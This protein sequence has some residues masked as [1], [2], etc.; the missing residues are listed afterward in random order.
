MDMLSLCL[1]QSVV[2]HLNP[3]VKGIVTLPL[4][5]GDTVP[6]MWWVRL[7]LVYHPGE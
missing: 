5:W 2:T 3:E 7:Q 1:L 4:F 6:C